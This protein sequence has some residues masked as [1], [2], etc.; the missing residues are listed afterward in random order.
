[1]SHPIPYLKKNMTIYLILSISQHLTIKNI[2]AVIEKTGMWTRSPLHIG[3]RIQEGKNFT[4]KPN[5][6]NC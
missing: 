1:M 4:K 3:M 2:G 6:E 5:L